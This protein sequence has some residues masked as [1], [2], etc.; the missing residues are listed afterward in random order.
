MLREWL[1]R[2][3]QAASPLPR[4]H[5]LETLTAELL[6]YSPRQRPTVRTTERL[7]RTARAWQE[8]T[9]RRPGAGLTRQLDRFIRDWLACNPAGLHLN[10][11]ATADNEDFTQMIA[12]Y[13]E[14]LS[15][16]V[17]QETVA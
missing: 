6:T 14:A 5:T 3:N 17:T 4:F 11:A 9:G 10:Y 12:R 7:L 15:D 13:I 2:S 8:A 16:S 1:E